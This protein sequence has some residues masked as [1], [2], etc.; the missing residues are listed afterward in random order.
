M[1]LTNDFLNIT[2][3]D[4]VLRSSNTPGMAREFKLDS[5][6]LVGWEDGVTARRQ[7][8]QRPVSNGDFADTATMG[9]RSLTITGMATA[10]TALDLHAMR[11]QFM[12]LLSDGQYTE[13]E[14]QN[15]T[16][17]RYATVGQ[18]NT[19]Q[20]VQKTD[21]I[22]V[23]KLDLFQPDPHIYGEERHTSIFG[24]ASVQAGLNFQ[25][26]S[27][28]FYL[29]YPLDYNTSVQQQ[30]QYISNAGNVNAWPVFTVA[31]NFYGGFTITDNLGHNITYKGD[32]SI[33]APV[34][35][36]T[37]NG[38]ASQ[39]GQDRSTLLTERDWFP[40]PPGG[41]IQPSFE[42]VNGASGWCDIIYRDTWL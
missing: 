5:N 19:P 18:D 8:T 16:G 20:W 7:V 10:K 35:I 25:G 13:I 34:K 3:K 6:A 33:F 4:V 42:P 28:P 24:A 26:T 9:A 17:K 15:I 32:A 30:T 36:D 27:A 37:A 1:I 40:V 23:F 21:T 38:S 29:T 2:I 39:N 12:G 22:A 14:V 31:G 11:D 41:S